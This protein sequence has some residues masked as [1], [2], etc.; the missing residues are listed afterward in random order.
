MVTKALSAVAAVVVAVPV[1]FVAAGVAVVGGS[2]SGSSQGAVSAEAAEVPVEM[3]SLYQEAGAAL[4]VSPGLLAG[5][6]KVECD[7]G[8]HPGCNEPNEAGAVGPM[9]FRPSTFARWA[10]ASGSPAPDPRNPRDAVFAAAAKLAADG[11]A[12]DPARALW[13]YNHSH[14]YVA[15]VEAWALAYGWRAPDVSVLESAVLV[16]PRIGLRPAAEDDILKG[17]VD[18]RVLAVLLVVATRHDLASVGPFVKDHHPFVRDGNGRPTGRMSNHAFGRAVDLP[19]VDG[20][21]VRLDK[22]A[23]RRATGIVDA[24]P[25]DLR[26]TEIGCPWADAARGAFTAGH[27]DH[28]HF[29]FDR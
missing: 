4:G 20:A 15:T 3:W 8:R 5:V 10:S 13:S 16:H 14:P 26:P 11:A 7:H 12:A 1:L 29:G 17:R 23:A 25:A 24:L 19:V 9:Q 27:D 21:A 2:R 6:G 28:L 22:E 18:G